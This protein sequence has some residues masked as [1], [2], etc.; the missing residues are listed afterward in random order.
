MASYHLGFGVFEQ[1]SFG[2]D[3]FPPHYEP[4]CRMFQLRTGCRSLK[5][6]TN[7]EHLL[8]PLP[9]NSS[10][11]PLRNTLL[12]RHACFTPDHGG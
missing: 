3:F 10:V 12:Y 7:H 9:P 6:Y 5:N 2:S 1:T 4:A 8:A 11:A